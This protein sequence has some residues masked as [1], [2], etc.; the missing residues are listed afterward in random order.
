MAAHNE[1]GYAGEAWVATMLRYVAPVEAGQVSDLRFEGL[2]IEVKTARPTRWGD[3]RGRRQ[4]QFLLYKRGHTDARPS[5]AIVL[6]CMEH[7]QTPRPTFFVIPTVEVEDRQKLG[8]PEDLDNYEGQW[9]PYREQWP[10][11]ADLLEANG[12]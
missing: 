5:D 6:V 3:G 7:P 12:E 4:Y 8:I 11:L 1:L 10:V 9:A 2:E